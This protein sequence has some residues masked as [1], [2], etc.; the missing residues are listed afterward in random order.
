M[1]RHNWVSIPTINDTIWIK[2]F[3]W[4]CSHCITTIETDHIK[5]HADRVARDVNVNP[6]CELQLVENIMES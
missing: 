6:D 4:K 2:T 1:R 3:R 5:D